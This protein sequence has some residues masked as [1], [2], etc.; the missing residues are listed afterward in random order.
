MKRKQNVRRGAFTLLEVLLVVGILALLAAFVVPNLMGADTRAK[1]K[2]AQM[3]VGRSGEIS[4]AL[5]QFR[6]D[7]GR[8]PDSDEGLAALFERPSSIDDDDER[9]RQYLEG[10]PEDLRD[11]WEQEY[12]YRCPGEF[13]EEAFDLWSYGPDQEDGTDDDEKNWREK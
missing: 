13:N 8:Y 1:K 11:P 6:L 2:L 12:Q 3:A 7:I 5:K 9:W 10:S 4:N